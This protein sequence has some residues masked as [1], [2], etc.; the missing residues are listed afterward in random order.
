EFLTP[1]Q[2]GVSGLA[3]SGRDGRI[4]AAA[5]A[6][7]TVRAWVTKTGKPAFTL[8]GHRGAATAVARSPDGTCLISGRLDRTVE[9]WDHRNHDEGPSLRARAGY[10][11]IAFSPAD[12]TL[13]SAPRNKAVL[14]WDMATGKAV[15][16]LRSVPESVNGL[17]F[18]ADG[19]QLASADS[20]GAIRVRE[21]P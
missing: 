3:F 13:A 17:A 8:R 6:D 7:N 10:T 20:D 21:V 2:A 19:V 9:L 15:V 16:R 18:S 12:G 11:S 14:I 5:S 4:L 1:S